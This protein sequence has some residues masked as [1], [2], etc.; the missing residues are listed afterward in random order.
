M[1]GYSVVDSCCVQLSES[2]N[3]VF[4]GLD[5]DGNGFLD[6]DELRAGFL[7][8]V[9]FSSSFWKTLILCLTLPDLPLISFGDVPDI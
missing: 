6:R 9:C 1:R 4:R 7:C 2:I 5:S 3:L 8:M